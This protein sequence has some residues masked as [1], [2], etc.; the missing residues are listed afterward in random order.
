M[1]PP[2]FGPQ[3]RSHGRHRRGRRPPNA[4]VCRDPDDDW[5][6]ATAITG[7]AEAI[8][9]CDGDLLALGVVQAVTILTPRQFIERS[10]RAR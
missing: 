6:L 5:V 1:A 7:E 10:A 8:V 3:H 9:T 4:Y 2:R